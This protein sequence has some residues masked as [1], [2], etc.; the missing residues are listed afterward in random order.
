MAN[1]GNVTSFTGNGLRDWLI[2]RVSAIILVAYTL[3]LFGFIF[4][5]PHLTYDVWLDLFQNLFVKIFTVLALLSIYSHAWIGIWT[6][7]TDYIK[8]TWLRGLL[9]VLVIIALIGYFVWGVAILWE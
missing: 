8:S 9:E 3:F 6:V 5:H 4:I 2:Q 1:V 7:L